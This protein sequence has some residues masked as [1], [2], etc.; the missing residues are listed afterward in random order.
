ME[1]EVINTD[2]ERE[3][4]KNPSIVTSQKQRAAELKNKSSPRAFTTARRKACRTCEAVRGGFDYSGEFWLT[5][6]SIADNKKSC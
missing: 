2:I 4:A 1:F 5:V 3:L 6:S